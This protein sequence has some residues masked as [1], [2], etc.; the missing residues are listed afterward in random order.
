MKWISHRGES[1]DAPENSAPAFALSQERKTSGMECDIHLTKDSFLVVCHDSDTLR[2]CGESRIIEESLYS[3]L[4]LLDA[5]NG[6]KEYSP[7][8][9]PLFADTLPF[10]GEGRMYFVEIKQDDPAVIDAMVSELEKAHIPPEQ[11]VMISFKLRIVK[12]FKEKHPH[13]KALLLTSFS[14]DQK[15]TWGPTSGELVKT[16]AELKA[17][18]VDISGNLSFI[19]EEYVEKVK[20][21]GYEFA[22][23]TVDDPKQAKRFIDFGVD[24]VTSNRAAFLMET[25]RG[26]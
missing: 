2:T 23:W 20:S 12:C 8:R 25:F 4:L 18:G 21:A 11:V 26:K 24:A 14:V 3:D 9:I 22:V 19:T 16:L 5:C 1:F 13:R 15:G 6:K 7:C 10:L 17:D